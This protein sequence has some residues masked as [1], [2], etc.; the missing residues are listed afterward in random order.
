ML[1]AELL[2]RPSKVEVCMENV[3]CWS[4]VFILESQTITNSRPWLFPYGSHGESLDH[5][6]WFHWFLFIHSILPCHV[7]G[8]ELW[9]NPRLIWD[10]SLHPQANLPWLLVVRKCITQNIARLRLRNHTI[11]ISCHFHR[12]DGD[13]DGDCHHQHCTHSAVLL[14]AHGPWPFFCEIGQ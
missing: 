14:V 5:K 10:R 6:W 12:P 7:W 11:A 8:T 3:N 4:F 1:D 2:T 9:P 13:S